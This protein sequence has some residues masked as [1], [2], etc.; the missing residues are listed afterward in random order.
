LTVTA[1]GVWPGYAPGL[2]PRLPF[3]LLYLWW[4]A[5]L[6]RGIQLLG[7]SILSD[8]RVTLTARS[9]Y[10]TLILAACAGHAVYQGNLWTLTVM[11]ALIGML[12]FSV[13]QKVRV[14]L[15]YLTEP[16]ADPPPQLHLMHGM[17]ALFFFFAGQGMVA[18]VSLV[19][20]AAIG[21][22]L[23][24]GY[25]VSGVIVSTITLWILA[26]DKVVW[27]PR[28][29]ATL[30]NSLGAAGLGWALTVLMGWGWLTV[31]RS[32][33]QLPAGMA[34]GVPWIIALAV[35]AAPVVEEIIFRGLVYQGLRQTLTPLRAALLSSV[36]FT[37]V[38]P[39]L[40]A[41]CVFLL[42]MVNA[43]LLERTGRLWSCMLVHAGYNAVIVALQ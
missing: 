29:K 4:L 34:L 27:L 35:V 26:R 22:A 23:V 28:A 33:G 24:L 13:W 10:L 43:V 7:L 11:A 37:I 17:Q 42:A 3:I 38:H 41:P 40:S 15:P 30:T 1:V 25:V 21:Q 20:G 5:E 31:L 12:N 6:L 9:T 16:V 32:R 8:T 2:L 14:D 18:Q 19:A 39:G 36:L